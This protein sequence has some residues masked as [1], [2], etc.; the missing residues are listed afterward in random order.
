MYLQ[1]AWFSKV[2][3]LLLYSFL[4]NKKTKTEL[5][6]LHNLF[7][8]E[9]QVSSLVKCNPT[10]AQNIRRKFCYI[11]FTEIEY[12]QQHEVWK[13]TLK[14]SFLLLKGPFF[15][16]FY[17]NKELKKKI[18]QEKYDFS[19]QD[20]KISVLV[21]IFF[22]YEMQEY[23]ILLFPFQIRYSYNCKEVL[24]KGSFEQK[25]QLAGLQTK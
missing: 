7:K 25:V 20:L 10:I 21:F 8:F 17:S 9:L 5:P 6:Y 19:H 22:F 14:N 11:L 24:Q 16:N 12:K 13:N 2:C 4:L 18:F 1:Y 23:L 3:S 15:V